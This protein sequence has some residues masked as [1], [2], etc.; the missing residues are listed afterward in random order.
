MK[1]ALKWGLRVAIAVVVL[2]LVTV[3][4]AYRSRDRILGWVVARNIQAQTGMVT[5]IRSFHLG[6]HD[7]TVEIKDM[8]LFNTAEFGGAPLLDI[9]EIHAEYDAAALQRQELHLT[10]L[11]F[12]LGELDIVKNQSGQTNI[13]SLGI[14]LSTAAA[15]AN[16]PASGAATP[17]TNAPPARQPVADMQ[18]A[19]GI[20]LKKGFKGIDRLQVS[21]GD[22]KYV[23]LQNPGNNRE[24]KIG[25]EN[26]VIT[27]VTSASDLAGLAVL[28]GL[29]SGDFF[30]SLVAPDATSAGSTQEILKLLGH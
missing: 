11:R 17:S 18:K 2:V 28:V 14:P 5:K 3:V 27:N 24:Q 4:L 22:F 7:S 23:D 20:D 15:T 13:F 26:C 30:K 9:P 10:L 6:F 12:N 21:I 25:I 29:R 1:P 8:K 16:A 19:T